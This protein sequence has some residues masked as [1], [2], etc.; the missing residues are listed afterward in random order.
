MSVRLPLL[1]ALL[2]SALLLAAGAAHGAPPIAGLD[3][4]AFE[5]PLEAEVEEAD[6]EGETECDSAW[7]EAD[8]GVLTEAEAGEVCEDEAAEAEPAAKPSRGKAG[9]RA[10]AR[11]RPHKRKKACRSKPKRHCSHRSHRH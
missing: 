3:T 9:H 10:Q 5:E 1:T 4:L 2:L 11:H 8:E 6:E 7:E